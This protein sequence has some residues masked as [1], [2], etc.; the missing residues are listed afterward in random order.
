MEN[1][2]YQEA[3]KNAVASVEI[4]GYNVNDNQKEIGLDFLS[5]KINREDF[6]N[7]ILKGCRV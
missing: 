3:L 6:V 4:E 7:L 1:D 5:G 2:I